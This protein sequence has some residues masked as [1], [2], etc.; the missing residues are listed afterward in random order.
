M[1]GIKWGLFVIFVISL[2]VWMSIAYLCGKKAGVEEVLSNIDYVVEKY[3]P[4]LFD[5]KTNTAYKKYNWAELVGDR[6][7]YDTPKY[8]IVT[9]QKSP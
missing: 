8:A 9:K 1:N 4:V 2:S 7:Y 6:A 5:N 3:P